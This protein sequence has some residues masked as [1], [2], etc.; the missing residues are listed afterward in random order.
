MQACVQIKNTCEHKNR[1]FNL[2]SHSFFYF[3][4]L[5]Y[6]IWQ[7]F[8][9]ISHMTDNRPAEMCIRCIVWRLLSARKLPFVMDS[10]AC[11]HRTSVWNGGSRRRPLSLWFGGQNLTHIPFWN[12]IYHQALHWRY[13]DVLPCCLFGKS[14]ALIDM[15]AA[16]PLHSVFK[17]TFL[18]R[19]GS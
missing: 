3:I 13:L 8:K 6:S 7:G 11:D 5:F 1:K 14:S 4:Y 9:Y 12:H 16:S 18:S 2:V 17:V 15:R 19:N 10:S